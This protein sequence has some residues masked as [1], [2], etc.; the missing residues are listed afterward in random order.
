MSS[1]RVVAIT[2]ASA[3]IGRAAALRVRATAQ[4]SLVWLNAVAPGICD[5]VVQKFGRK[6]A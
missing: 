3:G 5:C 2:G 1:R 4:R 6:R